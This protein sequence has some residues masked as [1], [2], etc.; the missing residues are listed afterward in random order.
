MGKLAARLWSLVLI[1]ALAAPEAGAS[2]QPVGNSLFF[3]EPGPGG[4]TQHASSVAVDSAG[5]IH[6]AMEF[7]EPFDGGTVYPVFYAYCPSGCDSPAHWTWVQLGDT[8]MYGVTGG[9]EV[10]LDGLGRPRVMWYKDGAAP[11]QPPYLYAECNSQ[12][13]SRG[14]WSVSGGLP[15]GS[16]HPNTVHYFA[17]DLFGRPRYVYPSPN[18]PVF[19]TCDTACTDSSHWSAYPTSDGAH[20]SPILAVNLVFNASG[21]P[22]LLGYLNSSTNDLV[23]RACTALPCHLTTNW[24][25]VHLTSLGDDALS[26]AWSLA[27]DSQGRPRLALYTDE[28]LSYWWSDGDPL[29]LSSWK[30]YPISLPNGRYG[31]DVDLEIDRGNYPH[32]AFNYLDSAMVDGLGVIVCSANCQPTSGN[33]IWGMLTPIETADDLDQIA[34]IPPQPPCDHSHWATVGAQPAQ[35]LDGGGNPVLLYLVMH[36]EVS[37]TQSPGCYPAITDMVTLRMALTHNN[38]PPAWENWKFYLALI[39]K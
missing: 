18:G 21:L 26:D 22:R 37:S 6:A 1:A 38:T 15:G 2:A 4:M 12:C 29:Q 39:K 14:S 8:G 33:A 5:G 16:T 35:A 28:S 9:A 31:M 3:M 11:G 34:S 27:L 32:L 13:A 36:A 30:H 23:Y 24:A 25:D 10:A 17:I 7:A 19:V 20:I